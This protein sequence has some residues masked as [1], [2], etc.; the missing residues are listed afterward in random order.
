MVCIKTCYSF[1]PTKTFLMSKTKSQDRDTLK[2]PWLMPQGTLT[3]NCPFFGNT[4]EPHLSLDRGDT[5]NLK[6]KAKP[7]LNKSS[8]EKRCFNLEGHLGYALLP[9]VDKSWEW[10]KKKKHNKRKIDCHVMH[11]KKKSI[12]SKRKSRKPK[13][14]LRKQWKNA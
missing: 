4:F 7:F 13:N 14:V 10:K 9:K 8:H 2:S 3:K 1:K 12:E 6:P 5:N 11:L